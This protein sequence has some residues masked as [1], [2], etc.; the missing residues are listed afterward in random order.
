MPSVQ[1]Q[2]VIKSYTPSDELNIQEKFYESPLTQIPSM[3][4]EVNNNSDNRTP[5]AD[6]YIPN[7]PKPPYG[8]KTMPLFKQFRIRATNYFRQKDIDRAEKLEKENNRKNAAFK[9]INVQDDNEVTLYST[10]QV[11]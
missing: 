9:H 5:N 4:V 10:P 11:D 3:D 7:A 6:G 1:A 2:R 8:D